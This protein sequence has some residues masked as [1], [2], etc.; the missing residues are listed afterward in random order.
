MYLSK[1]NFPVISLYRNRF[2]SLEKTL[3]SSAIFF[4][5]FSPF[6]GLSNIEEV[7]A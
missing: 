4:I 6:S 2:A 3:C 5:S 7:Q 1:E